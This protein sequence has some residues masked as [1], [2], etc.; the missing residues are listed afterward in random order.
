MGQEYCS[1]I[2]MQPICIIMA[3]NKEL[4]ASFHAVLEETMVGVYS[5]SARGPE[6]FFFSGKICQIP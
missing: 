2:F 6:L 5:Q 1:R 4:V 3:L